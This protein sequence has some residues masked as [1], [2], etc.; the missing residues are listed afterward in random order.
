MREPLIM[1]QGMVMAS[2]DLKKI[3]DPAILTS[4]PGDDNHIEQSQ[5]KPSPNRPGGF[6]PAFQYC[7][8]QINDKI[9][10]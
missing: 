5:A 1:M 7:S 3:I 6:G 4:L 8:G 10:M 2:R 9:S